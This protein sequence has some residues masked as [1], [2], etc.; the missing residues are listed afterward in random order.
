MEYMI[1]NHVAIVALQETQ[2]TQTHSFIKKGFEFFFSGDSGSKHHGVGFVVA[3]QM[4]HLV[5]NF[6]GYNGRCCSIDLN[7]APKPLQLICAYAP[8]MVAD[9][10]D[11]LSRKEQFWHFFGETFDRPPPHKQWCF[12]GDW[13]GSALNGARSGGNGH[14]PRCLVQTA[15]CDGPGTG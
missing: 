11:D 3:P 6:L 9:P 5:V 2:A 15:G 4:R 13:K 7:I 12:L 1:R 14:R 10:V 8:S